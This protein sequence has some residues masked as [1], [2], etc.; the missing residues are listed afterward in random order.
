M[1]IIN[2]SAGPSILPK[3]V[4][5]K[6]SE[7]VIDF[8]N[9][10]LSIL[11]ISHRS[12]DFEETIFAAKK[13]IKE[14]LNLNDEYSVL[15]LTGGA[16]TQFFMVPMNLLNEDEDA[17][18]I[19]TGTWSKNAIKEAKAFGNIKILASSESENFKFI[20]KNYEIPSNLKYLHITS[21]NTIF[22]TQY[23]EYP[24]TEVRLVSDM[25]SDIFSKDFD[26]NKFDL[27]YAGAQKNFGPAGVTLV[28]LKNEILGK[29]KR[30]I[31]TMLNYETH[32]KND[33]LYNTPPVFSIY[34]AKLTL[35]WIIKN[36]GLKGMEIRNNKKAEILYNEIDRNSLFTGHS[37]NEDR[38]KMNVCFRINE[39]ELEK[40]FLSLCENE[41]LIGLKGHR[42]VGG[43][44]ASIYN[45]M[46]INGVQKL[47]DV[48]KYF[49]EEKIK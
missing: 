25:S 17:G 1:E 19:N 49:E 4:F 6:A 2:F 21:N 37:I 12:K 34:V 27:I 33:S 47:V 22:G 29:V 11:E 46:E 42:S 45:A 14:L 31:P 38:S 20:P 44:R 18:Y 26:I 9:S 8:N 24:N 10:K 36:G 23:S 40:E 39:E 16:S 43:F 3:E 28:V 15:F 35:D 48:M 7:G 13:N 30:Y 41:G 32:L 5:E